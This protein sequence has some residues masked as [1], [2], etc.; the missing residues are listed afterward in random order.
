[1]SGLADQYPPASAAI[2]CRRCCCWTATALPTRATPAATAR[3]DQ[4]VFKLVGAVPP[5]EAP[6]DKPFVTARFF[7]LS[8]TDD[9]D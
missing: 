6:R 5:R 9:F 4:S 8:R 1:M 3:F 7:S 2:G